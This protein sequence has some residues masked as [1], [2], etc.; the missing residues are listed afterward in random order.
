MT[1]TSRPRVLHVGKFYPPVSG[2][3]E[4]VLQLLCERE[5]AE[6]DT[7]VLVANTGP[8]TVRETI[9][10]VSITR[11]ANIGTAGSVAVCPSL[12]LW[13]SRARADVIVIHEPN[14]MGLLA[15]ALAR[16]AGRLIVWFHSEVV[17]ARWQYALMYRPWF[18]Y[19]MRRASRVIVASPPMIAAEQLQGFQATVAV[20][21]YGVDDTRLAPSREVSARAAQLRAAHKGPLILFVGRMVPYKGLDV[22]LRAMVGVSATAVLVGDG[23]Q[24]GALEALARELGIASKVLFVGEVDEPGLVAW[25]HACDLFVLPSTTRAEAFGVVQTEAMACGKPVVSTA[26]P[27]GVPW[28]NR[29]GETGFVVPPGDPGALA[30]VLTRLASD[31]ALREAM[32]ERGRRR[33]QDEFTADR[34]AARAVA[35]YRQVMSEPAA[36]ETVRGSAVGPTPAAE[37]EAP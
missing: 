23:P 4:R 31:G 13:L 20:I 10:G 5:Q 27:S 32:G 14:P 6:V 34:M 36:G 8:A 26:V 11:V 30:S 12:P 28:V 35:L 2:G 3:M 9:D 22:L 21:P 18:A 16:P 1:R 25:Y 24:R 33:V 19:A 15:Y 7:R 17:R 29:D 37:V